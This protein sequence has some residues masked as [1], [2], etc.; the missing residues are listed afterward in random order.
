MDSTST[1]VLLPWRAPEMPMYTVQAPM[2]SMMASESFLEIR[3]R[4][5]SP[6]RDPATTV[7][8]L[9]ITAHIQLT[10]LFF[11]CPIVAEITPKGNP[12]FS[13]KHRPGASPGRLI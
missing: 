8:T 9:T 4:A 5:S 10:P 3:F 12:S 13:Q 7:I 1:R 2:P 11:A 6:T